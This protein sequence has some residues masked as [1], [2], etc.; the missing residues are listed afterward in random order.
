MHQAFC[1]VRVVEAASCLYGFIFNDD[2]EST[3]E[4]TSKAKEHT[5]ISNA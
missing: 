1:K 2:T 4:K 5:E 3:F